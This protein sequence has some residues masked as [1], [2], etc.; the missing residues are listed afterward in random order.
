MDISLNPMSKFTGTTRLVPVGA[1]VG[2][3]AID[4]VEVVSLSPRCQA[5]R[6]DI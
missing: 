5:V 4:Y 1:D 3:C 2:R 6:I